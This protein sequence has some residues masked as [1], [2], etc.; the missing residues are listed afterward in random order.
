MKP[1]TLT[2]GL[3][4]ALAA[5]AAWSTPATQ[6]VSPNEIV[7]GSIL[8]LS[9][10]ISQFGKQLR[11][12]M[13]LRL[14]EFNEQGGAHGR[15]VRL[16]VEDSA[17]DPKKAVL[18]AQKLVNS[19]KVFAVVGHIGTPT[20]MAALP[21]Q[22]DKNVFNFFPVSAG[23]EMYEPPHRLKYAFLV[24]YYD[25]MRI[26]T[27]RLLKDKGLKRPCILYQDDDFGLEILRGAED[28]LKAVN[29]TLVEKTSYKRGATDFS[30]QVARM[31]S[32]GC[33]LVVL[34]T[35]I[36]ETLGTV[37]EARKTGFNPVFLGNVGL[38][39]DLIHN[40]GGRSM[41]GLYA[42]MTM[43]HP[44]VD[45]P[46]QPIRFW[47]NKYKT[48]FGE[49]PSMLSAYGY[50]IMDTFLQAVGNAG[51]QLTTESFARAMDGLVQP[52]NIF[53]S[54]EFRFSTARRLASK[55]SRLSQI[56]DGR[57]KVVNDYADF[58]QLRAVKQK[59]GSV[60]YVSDLINE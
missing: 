48:R 43:Q 21:V 1:N 10:P 2:L 54:P 18:A 14:A 9:G 12:G 49:D 56:Q 20:N 40:L 33:D 32:A 53:G 7:V 39:S 35:I 17:Y 38:Y 28:G 51:P 22:F 19:D 29:T 13:S 41:D 37:S 44:Y 50:V 15:R 25:Q 4:L 47:A 45:S 5:P 24:S 31:K 8:D 59:D 36:R 57:W 52:P 3:A 34:G 60:K 46:E 16:V 42:T 23:R 58:N 30:S 11:Y 26:A 27:P 6:G 55:Y